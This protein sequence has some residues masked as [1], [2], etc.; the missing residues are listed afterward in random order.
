MRCL[1]KLV[2]LKM[3]KW[4]SVSLCNTN[5]SIWGEALKRPSEFF[6][7]RQ[8]S[9]QLIDFF[10]LE[11]LCSVQKYTFLF[12]EKKVFVINWLKRHC[13]LQHLFCGALY[14]KTCCSIVTLKLIR[15]P[16]YCY[17]A[18]FHYTYCNIDI[19]INI[20][21]LIVILLN[22]FMLS[23]IMLIIIMLSVIMLSTIMLSIIMDSIIMRSISMLNIIMLNFIMPSAKPINII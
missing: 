5:T 21:L 14:E 13:K 1:S 11:P 10:L 3:A 15:V 8:K 2:L 16:F 19:L 12:N 17:Y 9:C 22:L 23:I 20:I 7:S 6:F 4:N 18:N